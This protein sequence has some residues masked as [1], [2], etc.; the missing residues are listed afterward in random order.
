MHFESIFVFV[1]IWCEWVNQTVLVKIMQNEDFTQNASLSITESITGGFSPNSIEKSWVV[2]RS[3][4]MSTKAGRRRK[5]SNIEVTHMLCRALLSS[6]LRWIQKTVQRQPKMIFEDISLVCCV[7]QSSKVD[8]RNPSKVE[9]L[10]KATGVCRPPKCAQES[11]EDA[12]T[13]FWW[14]LLLQISRKTAKTA[15]N[16][17]SKVGSDTDLSTHNCPLLRARLS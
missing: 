15:K 13:H 8:L 2:P 11:G 10:P 17:V 3:C 14:W 12:Y 16:S 1:Q 5:I 7:S 6:F 9:L 4:K